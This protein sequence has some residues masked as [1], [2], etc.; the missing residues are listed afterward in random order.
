LIMQVP[1]KSFRP[2]KPN[3]RFSGQMKSRAWNAV[4]VLT[5]CSMACDVK[6]C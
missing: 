1:Q 4:F 6:S 5:G 3:H 2:G